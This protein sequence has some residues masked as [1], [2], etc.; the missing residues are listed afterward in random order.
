VLL[1]FI[2]LLLKRRSAQK[3]SRLHAE[4]DPPMAFIPPRLDLGQDDTANDGSGSVMTRPSSAHSTVYPPQRALSMPSPTVPQL[5]GK[6]ST[7]TNHTVHPLALDEEN[8]LS[9]T[10]TSNL[11][12]PSS[13]Q[14]H[15]SHD[16]VTN[17]ST[18]PHS[19]T[20][21]Q[22]NWDSNKPHF[23]TDSTIEESDYSEH[24]D[25]SA[26]PAYSRISTPVPVLPSHHNP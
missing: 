6:L 11:E 13:T 5:R 14:S 20:Y 12:V 15:F 18:S 7:R 2:F 19:P 10:S 25:D 16:G 3:K 22:H 24:A 21:I 4:I 26:P 1:L 9:Y 17:S 8:H 23:P